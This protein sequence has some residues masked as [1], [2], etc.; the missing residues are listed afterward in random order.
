VRVIAPNSLLREAAAILTPVCSE[1]VVVGALAVQV[2]LDGHDAL[3]APTGDIDVAISIES[4]KA[5][6]DH[7]EREGLRPSDLIYERGFTWV[8]GEVKVQLMAPFN[9]IARRR[10]PAKGLPV[11]HLV[12]ELEGHRWLVAF[13]EDPTRGLFYSVRPAALVALKE[14]AFGRE[15][16]DGQKV[17]RDFSDVALL[18]EK[19]G[20]QIISEVAAPSQMRWRV[21]RAATM[22]TGDEESRAAATRELVATGQEESHRSAEAMVTRAARDVVRALS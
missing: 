12:A 9:P 4:T 7:L 19:L 14:S 22:L 8:K 11:N 2:V 15:R 1:V 10:P 20:D 18:L 21:L 13:K 6:V 17:D 3:L 16:A 5:V